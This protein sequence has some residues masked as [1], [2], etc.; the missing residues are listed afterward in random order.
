[1]ELAALDLDWSAPQQKD[2]TGPDLEKCKDVW[3]RWD[4]YE[5]EQQAEY[6]RKYYRPRTWGR[7]AS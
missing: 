5:K 7:R 3:R 1:M 2:V 4:R 6:E